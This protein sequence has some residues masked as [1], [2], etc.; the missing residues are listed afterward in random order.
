MLSQLQGFLVCTD[1]ATIGARRRAL[2]LLPDFWA[3]SCLLVSYWPL[4]RAESRARYIHF[5]TVWDNL[6]SVHKYLKRSSDPR[7]HPL[8]KGP[9]RPTPEMGG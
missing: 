9:S 5:D 7:L 2:S 4:G 1:P 3:I 8:V 6:H